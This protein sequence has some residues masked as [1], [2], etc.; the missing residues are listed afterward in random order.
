[1]MR[2]GVSL[3]VGEKNVGQGYPLT[4]RY[5]VGVGLWKGGGVVVDVS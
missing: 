5:V 1:M 3:S 4:C 2:C